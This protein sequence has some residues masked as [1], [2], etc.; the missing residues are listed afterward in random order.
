MLFRYQKP[1]SILYILGVS[2]GEVPVGKGP[3]MKK[4]YASALT[5]IALSAVGLAEKPDNSFQGTVVLQDGIS[6]ETIS[7]F[8]RVSQVDAV[9]AA[10]YYGARSDEPLAVN[11][12]SYNN[13]VAWQVVFADT[14]F[15]IDINNPTLVANVP[16]SADMGIANSAMT[17]IIGS[18]ETVSASVAPTLVTPV[19]STNDMAGNTVVYPNG[20]TVLVSSNSPAVYATVGESAS[21]AYSV[22]FQ[23]GI[24]AEN[25]GSYGSVQARAAVYASLAH[26]K[27]T[28]LP[29]TVALAVYNNYYVWQVTFMDSYVLI[30]VNN[31]D[32]HVILPITDEATASITIVPGPI[33]IVTIAQ[34]A[35]PIVVEQVVATPVVVESV[36][37]TP[38]VTET[39]TPVAP[40][41][42]NVTENNV[43]NE[44]YVDINLGFEFEMVFGDTTDG[45]SSTAVVDSHTTYDSE[46]YDAS[47][48]DGEG[49]NREGYN[50][51][52][53]DREGYDREGYNA[54][55][56][57][58]EGYYKYTT[59][60]DTS[61]SSNV[62][63]DNNTIYDS[64]GYDANGFDNEGYNREGYNAS[65]YDREGYDMEGYNAEGYDREGY[66]KYTTYEDKSDVSV[67]S[68]YDSEGYDADGY[69]ASGYDREGY[70]REGYNSE[71]YDRE[72]Y[73]KYTTYQEDTS[74]S[75]YDAEGYDSEGY[76]AEGY[77]ASGY[78]RE[79]Y[80]REGYNS[81][82]YDREGYYKYSEDNGEKGNT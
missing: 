68:V 75:V 64:E 51:S 59:Y 44:V 24:T 58:R 12:A 62:S 74:V 27:N 6:I 54:E 33:Y 55:G 79:G 70:D 47:G 72:G 2:S 15:F 21:V 43:T 11:L 36:V 9:F 32:S 14:H 10:H 71:G 39:L 8:G 66:Y 20:E 1:T 76:D 48:F 25:I 82:G 65:G 50:A 17:T 52:G 67:D 23:E 46:G 57:D 81:E 26:T 49:Y 28:V 41:V 80:D 60:E 38:T 45:S 13:Y 35:E 16:Y 56:Y 34:V 63:V 77:S 78:D 19:M 40:V 37:A 18:T 22:P 31:A 5:V 4:I 7:D 3:G 73:Y 53:Y 29:Q 30:D 69:S 61:D 42:N